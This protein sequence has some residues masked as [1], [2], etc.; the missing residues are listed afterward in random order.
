LSLSDQAFTRQDGSEIL[1]AEEEQV[2]RLLGLPWIPP[3]L[4]EDR[5]EIQA[6][7]AGALPPL[8]ALAD[9][10][11]ELHA[12]STWSDGQASIRQ[13]AQAAIKRGK[14]VLAITD[15]SGSLG[16]AG[17]LSVDDLRRQ[18]EE[19]DAVQAELG[20][21]LRLLQGCEVEIMA[22]GALDYPDEVLAG[23][24]IVI[25]S[26]HSSLRQPREQVTARLLRAMHNP[27]VDIIGHPTG[28]IIPNREGADLDMEAVLQ[29]AVESGVALE[30]NADPSR[31]D[32]DD[33]TSRR[34]VQMGIPLSINTDAHNPESLD[35]A[36]FG[37]ATA[38]RGWVQSQ[39]VLNCWSDEKLLSWLKQRG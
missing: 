13:M 11:A 36:H 21:A 8:I 14:R 29:A 19:I 39:D 25:A 24:D 15:H 12:H 9:L 18:R 5:G 20:D 1:C 26:L 27:N 23:L 35:L 2:Y 10:R 3:E 17:G 33:I 31:L 34:A 6:A 37:V 22:D 30:I 32:L 7:R 4:R 28:R 38:R 16:V